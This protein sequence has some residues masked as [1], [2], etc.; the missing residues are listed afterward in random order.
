MKLW[1]IANSKTHPDPWTMTFEELSTFN[2]PKFTESNQ[3]FIG[4]HITNSDNIESILS[5]GI[6]MNKARGNSYGEPNWV[7]AYLKENLARNNH[8]SYI[9]FRALKSDSLVDQPNEITIR[10]NRDVPVSDILYGVRG[11]HF[12]IS[13]FTFERYIDEFKRLEMKASYKLMLE[14]AKQKRLDGAYG[15]VKL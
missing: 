8:N 3:Y 10:L 12:K 7:W 14:W 4:Y 13:G 6:L 11:Y 5:N 2:L 15:S 9:I 1:K